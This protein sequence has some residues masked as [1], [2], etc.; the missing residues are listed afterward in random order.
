MRQ[1][2]PEVQL[3]TDP[4]FMLCCDCKDNCSVSE[5]EVIEVRSRLQFHLLMD[6]N[7]WADNECAECVLP[8]MNIRDW[9]IRSHPSKGENCS[10]IA[11]VDGRRP[12]RQQTLHGTVLLDS[13]FLRTCCQWPIA[14]VNCH[15]FQDPNK[16]ACIQLTMQ[17]CK[18]MDMKDVNKMTYQYKRLKDC[19]QTG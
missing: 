14:I 3:T 17:G 4:G 15:S 5:P 11:R 12:F 7:E 8:H 1:F 2:A 9:C 16:C 10:E 13:S 6:V 19:I 18:A